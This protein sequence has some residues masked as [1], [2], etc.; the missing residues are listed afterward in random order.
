MPGFRG[1]ELGSDLVMVTRFLFEVMKIDRG[2][3]YRILNIL[4]IDMYTLHVYGKLYHK[5]V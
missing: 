4:T 3:D 5:G 1:G 2:D